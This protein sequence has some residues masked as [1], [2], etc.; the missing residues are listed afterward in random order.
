MSYHVGWEVTLGC[1][2]DDS[3]VSVSIDD[4]LMIIE[5][6]KAGR[7]VWKGCSAGWAGWQAWLAGWGG[8]H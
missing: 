5:D 3:C 6:L 8:E 4:C 1:T 7:A 2:N